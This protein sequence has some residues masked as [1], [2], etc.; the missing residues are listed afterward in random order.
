VVSVVARRDAAKGGGIAGTGGKAR[1]L[2][3]ILLDRVEER[4]DR[5]RPASEPAPADFQSAEDRD[6][7]LRVLADAERSGGVSVVRARGEARHMVNR[8]QLRDA[9]LLYAFLG[10][11]P[12]SELARES[13][14]N[15]RLHVTPR[16]PDASQAVETIA[17]GWLQGGRPFG[18]ARDSVPKAAEFILALDA[19]LGRE[20]LDR[21][22]L[23]TYS[24]QVTGDTKLLE[25]QA[26]RIVSF[27]KSTG[28]LD[29]ELSDVEAMASLGLE[30]FPQP[31]LI[32][33]PVRVGAADFAQLLYVGVAPEQASSIEAS[34][35]VKSVLT[36]ENLASFNRHVREVKQNGDVVVYTGGFPS[37]TVVA[38]LVA[39]SRW[40]GLRAIYHWGDVDEGGLRIALTLCSTVSIPIVPHLMTAEL[41]RRYGTKAKPAKLRTIPP[42]H[43]WHQL[44]CFLQS[45]GASHLEQEKIN[46]GAISAHAPSPSSGSD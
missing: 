28:R 9:S 35:P 8:V 2:L 25:R 10:R 11:P 18:L 1:E 7:F 40:P 4:P 3:G 33:G 36:I 22:D 26:G 16:T 12:A 27:F 23:R 20:P 30:K 24:G 45:D 21:R 6:A 41:A 44:V 13:I 32:S 14:A 29:A 46:P 17:S 15:L 42:G 31:V 19:V 39:I 5:T 43:P 38:A 34:T 37:R